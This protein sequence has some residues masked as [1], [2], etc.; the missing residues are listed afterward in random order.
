MFIAVCGGEITDMTGTIK[1]NGYP[2]IATRSKYAIE[3]FC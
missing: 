2:N 1:P 3:N